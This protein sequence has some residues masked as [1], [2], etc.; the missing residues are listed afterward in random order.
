MDLN[1]MIRTYRLVFS[2]LTPSC[3]AGAAPLWAEQ[4]LMERPIEAESA[5]LNWSGFTVYNA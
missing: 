2:A 4:Q 1:D 5:S 3:S